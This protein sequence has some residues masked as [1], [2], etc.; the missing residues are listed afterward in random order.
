MLV[1]DQHHNGPI[2]NTQLALEKKLANAIKSYR[3]QTE[4]SNVNLADSKANFIVYLLKHT[5]P[6][7]LLIVY[8]GE[9]HFF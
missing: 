7:Y 9:S 6:W 3:K 1:W 2:M 8:T 5:L 4:T